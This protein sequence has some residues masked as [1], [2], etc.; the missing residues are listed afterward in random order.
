[1]QIYCHT[2][3]YEC[4]GPLAGGLLNKFGA[5]SVVIAGS[6]ITAASFLAAS[7][8]AEFFPNVYFY[9]AIYGFLGG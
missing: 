7:T 2:K 4:L 9:M 6:L 3:K 1:M 8:I 5:R